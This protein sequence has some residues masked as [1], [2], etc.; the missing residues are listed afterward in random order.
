M[1]SERHLVTS[2]AEY[3]EHTE[4]RLTSVKQYLGEFASSAGQS[5]G[6]YAADLMSNP[7][8]AYKLIRRLAV[9]FSK[10]ET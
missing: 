1:G 4:E 5:A 7:L 8:Q 6:S 3:I 9:G 2:M 10:L